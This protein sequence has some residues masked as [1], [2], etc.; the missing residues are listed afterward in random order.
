MK[1]TRS[2]ALQNFDRIKD[3]EM[4]LHAL[5]EFHDFVCRECFKLMLK[6]GTILALLIVCLC[7]VYPQGFP[8]RAYIVLAVVFANVLCS[9]LFMLYHLLGY[10]HPRLNEKMNMRYL[11][12]LVLSKLRRQYEAPVSEDD[13]D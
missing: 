3:S 11:D 1:D 4:L 2:W 12:V 8:L 9:V 6:L 5:S 10:Y 7:F 13:I